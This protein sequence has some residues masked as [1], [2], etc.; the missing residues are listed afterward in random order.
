MA[1]LARLFCFRYVVCQVQSGERRL[2]AVLVKTK[3]GRRF[4]SAKEIIMLYEI[5]IRLWG[6]RKAERQKEGHSLTL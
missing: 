3:D 5:T 1:C 6:K 2:S 4:D